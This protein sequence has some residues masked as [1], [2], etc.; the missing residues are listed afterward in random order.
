M[1]KKPEGAEVR[2]VGQLIVADLVTVP[3]REGDWE[4]R[5][6]ERDIERV[7]LRPMDGGSDIVRSAIGLRLLVALPVKGRKYPPKWNPHLRKV[8]A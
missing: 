6:I 4:V 7:T 2:D 5:V 1:K 8:P 3:G